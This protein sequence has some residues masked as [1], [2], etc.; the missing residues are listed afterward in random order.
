MGKLQ[1]TRACYY[2][3]DISIAVINIKNPQT[4]K[5]ADQTML[6]R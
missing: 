6:S 1:P 2:E 4:A 3:K 5:F